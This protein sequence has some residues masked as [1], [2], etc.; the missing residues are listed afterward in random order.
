V[1]GS[2]TAADNDA[3]Q[4]SS[5]GFSSAVFALPASSSATP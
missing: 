2:A 3:S 4:Q 5:Q 1:R